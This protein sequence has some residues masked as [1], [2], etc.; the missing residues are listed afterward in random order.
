M[1]FVLQLQA[2]IRNCLGAHRQLPELLPEKNSLLQ[3][4]V[5]GKI[6]SDGLWLRIDK[7]LSTGALMSFQTEYRCSQCV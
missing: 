2:V 1:S 7:D 5:S 3:R 6:C 4:V